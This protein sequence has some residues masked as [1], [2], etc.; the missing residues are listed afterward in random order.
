MARV[1][2]WELEIIGSHGMAAKDYPAMLSMIESGKLK[3]SNFI[4]KIIAL[5]E[6]P[7]ALQNMDNQIQD[8]ITIII[9]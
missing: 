3:P 5:E 6:A 8:G 2:A 1:I 7:R 9:P 4:K